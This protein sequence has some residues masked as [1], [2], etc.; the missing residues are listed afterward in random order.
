MQKKVNVE[1][2]GKMTIDGK[3][4]IERH[5]KEIYISSKDYEELFLVFK[6]LTGEKCYQNKTVK[7]IVDTVA[8]EMEYTEV[9]SAYIY[10]DEYEIKEL[11]DIYGN[12]VDYSNVVEEESKVLN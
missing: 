7:K 3:E 10:F 11:D 9:H 1:I 12:A 4:T 8:K 6:Y 5:D 2:L